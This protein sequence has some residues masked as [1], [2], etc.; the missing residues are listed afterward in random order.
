MCGSYRWQSRLH[1]GGRT[2][3][4]ASLICVTGCGTIELRGG[5]TPVFGAYPY[6]STAQ[7]IKWCGNAETIAGGLP[8]MP[9]DL[10]LDTACLPLDLL[11]WAFGHYKSFDKSFAF[12]DSP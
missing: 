5:G 2:L 9:F 7:D 3:V 11:S 6:Q 10:I 12:P 1:D 4:L 8:S